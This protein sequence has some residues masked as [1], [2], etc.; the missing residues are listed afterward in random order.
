[1]AV[2]A[3]FRTVNVADIDREDSNWLVDGTRVPALDEVKFVIFEG[4]QYPVNHN[5]VNAFNYESFYYICVKD[6]VNGNDCGKGHSSLVCPKEKCC[7]CGE[8]GHWDY[9]CPNVQHTD[10]SLIEAIRVHR[11]EHTEHVE[12]WRAITEQNKKARMV[13]IGKE[14][15][16][17]TRDELQQDDAK[18]AK[19]EVLIIMRIEPEEPPITIEAV[20]QNGAVLTFVQEW[21]EWVD[22]DL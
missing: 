12:H 6:C 5:V 3:P 4:K 9:V 8:L 13:A 15:N 16:E 21:Y 22:T 1:M 14:I 20:K 19:K 18:E 7:L 2:Q 17:I 11:K 10:E